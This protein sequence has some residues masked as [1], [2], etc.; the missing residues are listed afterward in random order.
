MHSI[1]RLL[2]TSAYAEFSRHLEFHFIQMKRFIPQ[3]PL[4][5]YSPQR[6]PARFTEREHCVL[7]TPPGE[8]T[9]F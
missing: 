2:E 6:K 9:L 3:K 7:E 1:F 8:G 5:E 4:G